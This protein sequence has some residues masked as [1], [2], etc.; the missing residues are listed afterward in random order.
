MKENIDKITTALSVTSG[1]APWIDLIRRDAPDALTKDGKLKTRINQN[2][3][4]LVT[5]PDGQPEKLSP[6]NWK[7]LVGDY[8]EV[9]F[10]QGEV[11]SPESAPRIWDKAI[12]SFRLSQERD[13]PV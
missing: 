5:L 10:Y 11:E 1:W 2:Q 3:T 12:E 13:K 4:V 6:D 8:L 9:E 7:R